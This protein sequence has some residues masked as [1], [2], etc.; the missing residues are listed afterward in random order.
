MA[1]SPSLRAALTTQ[2]HASPQPSGWSRDSALSIFWLSRFVRLYLAQGRLD[3]A[4]ER[5]ESYFGAVEPIGVWAPVARVLPAAAQALIACGA[6]GDARGLVN[7]WANRLRTLD[8]P[9]A[10]AALSHARGI[11]E[12]VDA[13]WPQ[14]LRHLLRAAEAYEALHCPYEAAQASELAAAALFATDNSTAA[15]ER[16]Q[17]SAAAYR[18]MGASWDLGRAASTA[19]QQGISVPGRYRAGRRGY[20]G[21]LSPREREVAELAAT[22]R[23]NKEIGAELFLSVSTVEKHLRAVARKLGV[24]SRAAITR[25]VSEGSGA[26]SPNR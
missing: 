13:R 23:T 16:L 15:A 4:R 5:V 21:Q 14:V 1:A 25:W 3:A 26:S 18:S 24:R 12:A 8:S 17:A 7:D 10:P 20:G 19:R 9:L 22:G 11:V 6:I 2:I